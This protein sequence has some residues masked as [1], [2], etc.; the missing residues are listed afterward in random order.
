MK[1]HCCILLLL[2]LSAFGFAQNAWTLADCINHALQN[3]IQIQ[4]ASIVSQNNLLARVQSE[5]IQAKYE[6][7]FNAKV[8]D[9]YNGKDI[10]F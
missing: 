9:F 1:K 6:F 4:Q 10:G 7:I 8:L 5:Q 3:N 2:I